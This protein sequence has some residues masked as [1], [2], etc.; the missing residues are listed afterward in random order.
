MNCQDQDLTGWTE[1][2]LRH[3]NY[4]WFY[5]RLGGFYGSFSSKEEARC[6]MIKYYDE[7]GE[8]NS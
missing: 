4:G 2:D 1:K 5:E 3:D 8:Y 6:D 7:Q